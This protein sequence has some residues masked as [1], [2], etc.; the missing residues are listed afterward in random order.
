MT[1][2]GTVGATAC[3]KGKK[4]KKNLQIWDPFLD[5]L[6]PELFEFPQF[7]QLIKSYEC[8]NIFTVEATNLYSVHTRNIH[9][10]FFKV[11][12]YCI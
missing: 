2:D 12:L 7:D 5:A 11:N 6:I 3:F 9:N 1:A 10:V 4:T 8:P